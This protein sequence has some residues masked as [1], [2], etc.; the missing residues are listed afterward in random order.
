MFDEKFNPQGKKFKKQT[1]QKENPAYL[2]SV[3]TVQCLTQQKMYNLQSVEC[4]L[5][6]QEAEIKKAAKQGNKQV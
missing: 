3:L 4:F 1:N 2:F 6:L 5:F